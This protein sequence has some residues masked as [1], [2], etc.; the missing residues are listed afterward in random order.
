V[1][2]D[3]DNFCTR[4]YTKKCMDGRIQLCDIHK[5]VIAK[6]VG[7]GANDSTPG[8]GMPTL[9]VEHEN[10]RPAYT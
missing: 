9:T 7:G 2:H 3:S 1:V 4:S 10:G 6:P 8:K 5:Q